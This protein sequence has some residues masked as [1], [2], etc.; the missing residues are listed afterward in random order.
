MQ[1]D[2]SAALKMFSKALA[3][4]E[5]VLG[6]QHPDTLKTKMFMALVPSG[7]QTSAKP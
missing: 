2:L 5:K 1:G 6:G 7:Q 4:R 3:V